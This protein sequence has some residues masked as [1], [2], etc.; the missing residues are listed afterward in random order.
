MYRNRRKQK[1]KS[2]GYLDRLIWETKRNEKKI[3]EER[4]ERKELYALT[5]PARRSNRT[6]LTFEIFS[7]LLWSE[8]FFLPV[9]IFL[10]FF[11]AC[12]TKIGSHSS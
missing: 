4:E 1:T 7:F 12:K 8:I 11:F 5:S 3:E 2:L 9:N 10:L 6:Y